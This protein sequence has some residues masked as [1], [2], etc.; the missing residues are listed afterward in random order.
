MEIKL[1]D[2]SMIA[3]SLIEF[4]LAKNTLMGLFGGKQ[5]LVDRL[6]VKTI[7]ID[8]FVVN[9][10]FTAWLVAKTTFVDL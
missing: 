7:L 10:I 6:V 4:M 2:E 5:H 1:V 3:I 9:I 8:R